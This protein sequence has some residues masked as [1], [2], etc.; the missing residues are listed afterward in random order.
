VETVIFILAAHLL[1]SA[2]VLTSFIIVVETVLCFADIGIA[3]IFIVCVCGGGVHSLSS[4]KVD[5]HNIQA[6]LPD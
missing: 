2:I 5:D 4:S 1:M 6:N 3:R